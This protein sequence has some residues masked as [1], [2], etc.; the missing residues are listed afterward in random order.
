[1]VDNMLHNCKE[2]GWECTMDLFGTGKGHMAECHG[3]TSNNEPLGYVKCRRF[4]DCL[5][6]YQ[7]S[8]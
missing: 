7:H 1:M 6:N 4:L 3:R 5:G 2:T 8:E